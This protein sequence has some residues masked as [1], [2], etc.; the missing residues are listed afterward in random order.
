MTLLTRHNGRRDLFTQLN[1]NFNR[2]LVPF[3]LRTELG[4]PE[5]S[6]SDWIPTID[7]KEEDKRYVIHADVPGV[8]AT[9]IDVSM[10]NGLLTIKGKRESK[11]KEE[12]ENYLRIERSTGS[13]LRQLSLPEAVDLEHIEAKCHDG[14]LEITLPKTTQH[15]GRKIKVKES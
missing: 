6:V 14:V 9:D 12:K 15:I 2:M 1:E 11:V 5:I 13:F 7:V 3:D 8:K 10:E 4:Y